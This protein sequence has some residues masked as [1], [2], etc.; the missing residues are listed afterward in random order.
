MHY[1]LW[2]IV[3]PLFP[4]LLYV[5]AADLPQ[6]LPI[7]MDSSNGYVTFFKAAYQMVTTVINACTIYV[8]MVPSSI[9]DWVAKLVRKIWARYISV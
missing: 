9:Y 7:Y 3:L 8:E 2:S 6:L 1:K 4:T 5:S